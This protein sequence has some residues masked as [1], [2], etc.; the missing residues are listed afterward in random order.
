LVE[1]TKQLYRPVSIRKLKTHVLP[2]FCLA[3]AAAIVGESAMGED[4]SIWPTVD[5]Q[6]SAA[7]VIS[8]SALERLI[9]DNQDV[10]ILRPEEAHDHLGLPPWLRVY[11]RKAHPEGKYSSSDPSGGYPRVLKRYYAWMLSHQNL[12]HSP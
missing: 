1:A 5:E 6:L 12:R 10:R 3:V 9:R 2:V 7:K 4:N 11:W 8:G